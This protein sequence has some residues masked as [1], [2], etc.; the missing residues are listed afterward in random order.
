MPVDAGLLRR[1]Y[2]VPPEEFV[3]A[4]NTTVKELRAADQRDTAAELAKLRRPSVVDWALNSVATEHPD[5]MGDALDA[6][7]RLRDAQTAAVEG[8]SGTD[9][10]AAVAEARDRNQQ[11]LS[12][13]AETITRSGRPVGTLLAP[14]AARLSEVVANAAAVEQLRAGHLGSAAIESVDPFAGAAAPSATRRSK[15]PRAAAPRAAKAERSARATGGRRAA[16]DAGSGSDAATRRRLERTTKAARTA[17]AA[18]HRALSKADERVAAAADDEAA[19]ASALEAARAR[20]AAAREEQRQAAE[21]TA[22]AD[23]AVEAAEAAT[24]RELGSAT[25]D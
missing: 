10:R 13:A 19:A 11:I 14:L 7:A 1:L 24:R 5:A 18:A 2:A 20:L 15:R 12:L 3:A 23:A 22:T 17:Q 8:R 21:H 9:V 6:A 25:T 4:R 16:A